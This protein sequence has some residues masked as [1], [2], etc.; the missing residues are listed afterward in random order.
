[1]N[2]DKLKVINKTNTS[3][4]I[5]KWLAGCNPISN[6]TNLV[7]FKEFLEKKFELNEQDFYNVFDSLEEAEIGFFSSAQPNI[8]HWEY[9]ITDVVTTALHPNKK[10]NV[11]KY[12][13]IMERKPKKKL[14]QPASVPLTFN[15]K[16][17]L[18]DPNQSKLPLA[19]IT[20]DIQPE[21][22]ETVIKKHRGRPPGA[23]NKVAPKTKKPIIGATVENPLTREVIF[24]FTTR[25]GTKI[26]F[27]LDDVEDLVAQAKEIQAVI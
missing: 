23:K 8:F 15:L 5:F 21:S 4:T 9:N 10:V 14:I 20:Q 16:E 27:R 6:T 26:P 11:R 25:R 17:V 13:E 2:L 22:K 19:A 1:M 18:N 12:E 7:T 3:N 24:F